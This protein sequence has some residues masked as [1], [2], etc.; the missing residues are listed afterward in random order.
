[1]LSIASSF[2]ILLTQLL[3]MFPLHHAAVV[4][5]HGHYR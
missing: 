3:A 4:A 1:L 5:L 2:S